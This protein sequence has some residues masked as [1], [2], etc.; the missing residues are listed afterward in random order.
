MYLS[1]DE[2]SNTTTSKLTEPAANTQ[3]LAV[4][5]SVQVL[6][7]NSHY[8]N[9][10]ICAQ[11]SMCEVPQTSGLSVWPIQ[12]HTKSALCK[13]TQLV[14]SRQTVS[15][16]TLSEVRIADWVWSRAAWYGWNMSTVIILRYID[17]AIPFS[18]FKGPYS[19]I[20]G[21]IIFK[22]QAWVE[23]GYI[24]LICELYLWNT[25]IGGKIK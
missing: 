14:F 9:T 24:R 16:I 23:N 25:N 20:A 1:N 11:P 15:I 2:C 10:L 8:G 21:S 7:H 5:K 17:V 3:I 13:T 22:V 6:M 12:C 18:I 19:F 4:W